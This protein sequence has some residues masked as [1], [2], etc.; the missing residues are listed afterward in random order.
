M[1]Q[2]YISY[3]S[4]PEEVLQDNA[5]ADLFAALVRKYFTCPPDYGQDFHWED[6]EYTDYEQYGC[7]WFLHDQGTIL[8]FLKEYD[9]LCPTDWQC[10]V[11]DEDGNSFQKDTMQKA[12]N[13]FA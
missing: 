10:E 9:E 3:L 11:R 4:V 6:D 12:A 2:Y 7:N 1:K 8:Q 13:I 5:L